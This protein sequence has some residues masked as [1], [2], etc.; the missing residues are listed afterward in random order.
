MKTRGI[1]IVDEYRG[2]IPYLWYK[3]VDL[4]GL[5]PVYTIPVMFDQGGEFLL[6]RIGTRWD[7]QGTD[8]TDVLLDLRKMTS[9]FKYH[10]SICPLLFS[11]PCDNGDCTISVAPLPVDTDIFSRLYKGSR[12][13][14]FKTY[15]WQVEDNCTVVVDI[16]KVNPLAQYP[17]Y[18]DLL[19][20][21]YYIEKNRL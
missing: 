13:M 10:E 14:A 6:K 1:M 2:I 8:Y 9:N 17:E 18:C 12:R 5:R 11:S 4:R 21:G 3:R 19:L 7:L 16:H 15:N 20:E